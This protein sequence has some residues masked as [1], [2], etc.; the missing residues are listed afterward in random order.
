MRCSSCAYSASKFTGASIRAG[1]EPRVTRL[2]RVSR[3][4]GN[5][6]FGQNA[7]RVWLIEASSRFLIRKIPACC[8]SAMNATSPFSPFL[9]GVQIQTDARL[10]LLAEDRRA[11][12]GF[13]G[14]VT[15]V[16]AL[17][18]ELRCGFF[19]ASCSVLLVSHLRSFL[20]FGLLG[21][22]VQ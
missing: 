10:P 15:Y 6:M 4:Y 7:P 19:F 3:A 16:D 5:R 17:Q 9:T 1:N 13:E 11:F 8:T 14:Q 22:A 20:I 18:G 12:R 2:S 21:F